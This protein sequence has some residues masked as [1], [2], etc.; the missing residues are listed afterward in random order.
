MIY[1]EALTEP[2]LFDVMRTM[3]PKVLLRPY[4]RR[5]KAC[6]CSLKVREMSANQMLPGELVTKTVH[7]MDHK[8]TCVYQ[9]GT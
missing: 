9:K 7:T 3:S 8:V 1:H 6:A 4:R 2:R 5:E